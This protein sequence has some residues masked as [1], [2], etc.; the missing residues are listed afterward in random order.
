MKLGNWDIYATRSTAAC[1]P[2]GLRLLLSIEQGWSEHDWEITVGPWYMV[3][4]R[5]SSV[6][7]EG[8]SRAA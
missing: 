8:Y 3:L 6:S 2:S 4:S 7:R 1:A 5:V